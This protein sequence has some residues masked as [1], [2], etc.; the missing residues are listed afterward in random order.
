MN[1]AFRQLAERLAEI[2]DLELAGHILLWD[3]EV[4]MPPR[5]SS[6]RAEQLATLER[7][8][9]ERFISDEIGR[10]LESLR[11]YEAV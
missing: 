2:S 6:I 3:Q 9:H 8:A 5:G 4:V 10:L 7:I 1:T 11:P